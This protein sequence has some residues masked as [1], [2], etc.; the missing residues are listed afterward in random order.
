MTRGLIGAAAFIIVVTGMQR[1]QEIVVPFLMA[2]FLAVLC[3]PPIAWLERRIGMPRGLAVA[4]VIIGVIVGGGVAAGLILGSFSRLAEEMPAYYAQLEGLGQDLETKITEMEIPL[5]DV[6]G[7]IGAAAKQ[8][9]NPSQIVEY[10]TS[11]AT[12]LGGVLSNSLLIILLMVFIL[13]EGISIRNKVGFG[14]DDPAAS[15]ARLDLMLVEVNRYM[16]LKTMLSLLTGAFIAGV[17]AVIGL[18]HPVLWGV[19]A[20]FLNY[21]PNLGSIIAAVPAVLLALLQGGPIMAGEVLVLYVSVNMVVGNVVEPKLMGDGLGLSTLIVFLSLVFWGWLLGPVGMLLSVPL[22]MAVKIA[23]EANP[24][25]SKLAVWLGPPGVAAT[26]S[27]AAGAPEPAADQADDKA[28][29]PGDQS[30]SNM[31]SDEES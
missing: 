25:G 28:G 19:V 30:S 10:S 7:S 9:L 14:G 29:N 20:F 24:E 15:R 21:I 2:C 8:A 6:E 5:L 3:L 17:L 13:L 12:Q 11:F 31:R 23:L 1:A 18:D 26:A 16:G 4:L 22:T 27:E